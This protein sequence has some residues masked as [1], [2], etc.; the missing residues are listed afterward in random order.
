MVEE[1]EVDQ[2]AEEKDRQAEEEEEGV[3]DGGGGGCRRRDG[4]EG[5]HA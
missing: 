1:C 2:G 3:G 5:G 4:H